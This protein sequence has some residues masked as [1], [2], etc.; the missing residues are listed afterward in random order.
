LLIDAVATI[1]SSREYEVQIF[2]DGSERKRLEEKTEKLGL[3]NIIKFYGKVDFKVMHDNYQKADIFVLPSLRETTGTSV[4]E[5]MANKLPIVALNQN[6]VKYLVA[7]DAGILVDVRTRDQIIN[8]MGIA[9]AKLID[10]D[11]LRVKLGIRG[12]NKIY[13]EY[14]WEQRA[15]YMIGIYRDIV[16]S[17]QSDKDDKKV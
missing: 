3:S 1:Q 8:D 5:A 10:N 15:K 2:G 16:S 13:K 9:L 4:I 14:T 6:G 7:E 11:K 12:F 17:W